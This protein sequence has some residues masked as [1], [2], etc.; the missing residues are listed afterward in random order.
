MIDLNKKF[1]VEK[2]RKD[3]D[4]DRIT[5][6]VAT[7]GI[8]A[9]AMPI[10]DG[11]KGAGLGMLVEGVGCAGMCFAEPIVTVKQN[12]IFS[13]YGYVIKEKLPMLIESIK[14]GEICKELLMGHSLGEIEYYKKQKRLLMDNCGLISP[15]I[16]E[17][18]LARGGYSGLTAALNKK[19][20]EVVD[21]IKRSGLRGR[22]GAGFS[23]G[24]KWGFIASK[25]GRKFVICNA[26]EG[27]PGAFM[28]RT[29]M[30]SDPF[31]LIEGI[32][33][34]AYAT[35]AQEGIIYVRAEKPLARKTVT[36]ATE[37]ARQSGLIGKDIFGIEGFCFD[38]KVVSGAGAFVCGEETALMKS[39]EG[40]RG[41]P[42]PRP[43]YPAEKGIYGCPT[44]INNV[45]TLC[46]VSTI[47]KTG[48]D[49]YI[50]T[51]TEKTKGTHTICLTGDIRRTGIAEV[52]IGITLNEIVY[53]I[54]GGCPDGSEVKAVQ[55]GGPSGG[56]IP[57]AKFD[58]PLD[59]EAIQALGAI[60]GSGGLVV[61]ST[62]SCMV[63]VARYFMNFVQEE[64][65]GKCT[66]CREGT[67]RLLEMLT[68][69]TEGLADEKI[70][71]D[72]QK[73]ALYIK[74]NSLCGLGQTAPN[75]VLSTMNYFKE[76]YLAHIQKKE[77][78]AGSCKHL[79]RYFI[80]E[81]CVGCGNCARH[82]P[83]KAI[84]GRLKE[85]HIIDQNICVKCGRCYENC[86]FDAIAR[87]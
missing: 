69:I 9:G 75:P 64:S 47:L 84:T 20:L 52:P 27:D 37:I 72:I 18:Y 80:T 3:L 24:T 55:S 70:L 12:S 21:D 73:L 44:I 29:I 6:G 23:T 31:R 83:V 48:V 42:M 76:E 28:N 77:C 16:V 71:D 40:G 35:G 49:E 11:L 14:K 10:L 85:R 54:G 53:D 60:M 8:A 33:I 50:K 63:D 13:I 36:M 25:P 32:T 87:N 59:Y 68:K 15:L 67:R 39:A 1:N 62:R 61:M 79:T 46:Q 34:A 51:G 7:C 38:I 41:N 22:G 19:P 17:Q 81:K 45:G 86:A 74:D 30:E 57:R 4:G 5:V 56:C 78:P 65:C 2:A 66:P 82:C 58:T 43:P 26:D